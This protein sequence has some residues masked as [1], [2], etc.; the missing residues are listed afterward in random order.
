MYR[1]YEGR[2]VQARIIAVAEKVIR[3]EIFGVECSI[4]AR[5]LAWDWVG[6]AHERF[7]WVTR[8]WCVFLG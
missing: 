8:F 7:L 4:M 3:V 1:I 6:D 2:V 5:D